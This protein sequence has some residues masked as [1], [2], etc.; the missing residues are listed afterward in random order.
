[1]FDGLGGIP[2]GLSS[3]LVARSS[4]S[5]PVDEFLSLEGGERVDHFSSPI[6]NGDGGIVTGGQHQAVQQIL[7]VENIIV[8]QEG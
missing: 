6:G 3:R 4:Q 5:V 8:P 1:M 2:N 7:Q